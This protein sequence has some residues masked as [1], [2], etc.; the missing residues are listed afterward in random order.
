MSRDSFRNRMNGFTT[1][2]GGQSGSSQQRSMTKKAGI[3]AVAVVI[4]ILVLNSTYEIKEQEQ[5]RTP[6]CTS[7]FRSYNR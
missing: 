2:E 7:R 4:L 5:A 3:I 1:M 6:A